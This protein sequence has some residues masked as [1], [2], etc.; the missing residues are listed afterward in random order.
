MAGYQLLESRLIHGLDL[1]NVSEFE[2][3]KAH[4]GP[5]YKTLTAQVIDDR[6]RET[7]EYGSVLFYININNPK[8]Q[9]VSTVAA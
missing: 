3:I 9:M 7:T 8:T 1:L 5:D 6:I 4:L 2:Q